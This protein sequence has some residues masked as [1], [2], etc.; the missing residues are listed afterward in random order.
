MSA[1]AASRVAWPERQ[2]PS[3]GPPTKGYRRQARCSHPRA[4]IVQLTE[5]P[6]PSPP[7]PPSTFSTLPLSPI[8]APKKTRVRP[9]RWSQAHTAFA[10]L[11]SPP[12]RGPRD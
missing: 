6:A 1:R 5:H 8:D 10:L 9:S 4:L 12:R 7:P 11:S 2:R 3:Q